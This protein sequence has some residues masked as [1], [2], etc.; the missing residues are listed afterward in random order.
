[1]EKMKCNIAILMATYNGG[2]YLREQINSIIGQSVK[3]WT[4]YVHDDGSSD[5]TNNILEEYG[6]QNDNIVTLKYPSQKGAKNNFLSL[7]RM[8]EADYYLFCDQDDVWQKNKIEHEIREMKEM[9]IKYGNVPLLVFSDLE[10]VDKNMNVISPSMWQCGDI[11]PELLTSFDTGAVF[12]YVTGCTMLFNRKG[13]E[14]ICYPADNA[15][16]HDSWVY[17]CIL[18]AGGHVN[19]LSKQLV[20]YRQHGNNTLGA[21]SWASHGT[22]YK[23]LNIVKIF[24][25]NYRHWKMLKSL[26]Y[27]S[28]LKYLHYKYLN[29]Y[30]ELKKQR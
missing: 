28:F 10:V 15:L 29:R 13:R 1:M 19:G 22:L 27:G 8:V 23:L 30:V 5:D 21:T 7:V 4:L 24:R 20:S 17:C 9:E 11:H 16:M 14:A 25:N 26:G 2:E 18:K 12:E 6:A 3:G